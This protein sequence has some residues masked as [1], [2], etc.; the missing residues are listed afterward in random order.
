[1]E[2]ENFERTLRAFKKRA[3]FHPFTVALE[4]GDK[5]EIDHPDALLIRDGIAV[6]VAP[7]G[8][9]VLFDHEGVSQVVGDLM[10]QANA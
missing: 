1:M 5:F 8:I 2:A 3:P 9:P 6:Y 7:G 4:N 10:G